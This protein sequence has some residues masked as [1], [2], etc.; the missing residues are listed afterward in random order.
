[1]CTHDVE[2]CIPTHLG[3]PVVISAR[4]LFAEIT[5]ECPDFR[6]LPGA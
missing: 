6:V 5:G 4:K 3:I 2:V 1:M